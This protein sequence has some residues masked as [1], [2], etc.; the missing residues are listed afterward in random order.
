MP[1]N[2]AKRYN[3]KTVS[4]ETENQLETGDESGPKTRSSASL[5]SDRKAARKALQDIVTGRKEAKPGQM[6]AIKL[7]L[8]DE[9]EP[10]RDPNPWAGLPEDELAERVVVTAASVLGV[11]RLT[12]VLVRLAQRGEADVLHGLETFD[13]AIGQQAS[14]KDEPLDIEQAPDTKAEQELQDLPE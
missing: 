2:D 11:K 14:P 5:A 7:L 13:S 10:E 9:I 4:S 8:Q 6:A 12:D 3:R 1:D